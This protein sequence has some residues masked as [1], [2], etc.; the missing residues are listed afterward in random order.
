MT[1]IT[2]PPKAGFVLMVF[3]ADEIVI[4]PKSRG[5]DWRVEGE[6][7][8]VPSVSFAKWAEAASIEYHAGFR[9]DSNEI[10]IEC[11]D[12]AAVAITLRWQ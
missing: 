6:I 4:K 2:A 8:A 10:V 11:D 7:I 9:D 1:E 5:L 12:A 3:L